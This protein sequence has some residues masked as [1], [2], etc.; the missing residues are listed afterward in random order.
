MILDKNAALERIEF[1]HELYDEICGI[2]R[3]DA[4]KMIAKLKEA[5]SG[6]D[7]LVA[8]RL[9]H[10]LKSAAANIGAT[11]LSE[12]ARLAEN[13]FRAENLKNII[14]LISEIDRNITRV[15]ETLN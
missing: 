3:E 5:C 7:I 10:S 13:A 6:G 1:D 2:F 15:L 4:P 8:T 9:A 12:S 11:D 14:H